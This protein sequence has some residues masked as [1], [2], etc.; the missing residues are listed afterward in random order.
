MHAKF[1]WRSDKFVLVD[2]STNGTH[3]VSEDGTQTLLRMEEMI[4]AGRGRVSFGSPVDRNGDDVLHY[5][6]EYGTSRLLP[7]PPRPVLAVVKG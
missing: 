4:L 5:S 3:V 6:C 1:E 7:Q 2:Q